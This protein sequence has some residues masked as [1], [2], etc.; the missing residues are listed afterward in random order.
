MK[1]KRQMEILNIVKNFDIE[2]QDDL[3]T[4]L[5]EKNYNVTQ[6]TLSR[7]VRELSLN[8]ISRNG[9]FV[10][11]V[12][13]CEDADCNLQTVKMIKD[14]CVSVDIACNMVVMHTTFGMATG[15]AKA[16]DV[17]GGSEVVGTVAGSDT[18]FCATRSCEM[19]VKFMNKIKNI[20]DK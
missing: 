10:Y 8:K 14:N 15:V 6:A 20:I 11:D 3:K 12:V 19:A 5:L 18:L 9:K 17:I 2:T 7:D 4:R 13:H 16:I 1:N